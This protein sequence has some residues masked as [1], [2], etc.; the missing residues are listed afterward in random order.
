VSNA[1]LLDKA[2]RLGEITSFEY[3]LEQRFY[4]N[5]LLHFL[6]TEWNYQ[7]VVAELM[8]YKL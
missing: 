2:L 6:K 7:A 4:Q 5:A 8:Q 1:S 3:F